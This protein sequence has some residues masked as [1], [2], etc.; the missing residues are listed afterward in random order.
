[1]ILQ[2]F[3]YEKREKTPK[4]LQEFFSSTEGKFDHPFI[5]ELVQ[6]LYR[7]REEFE[8]TFLINGQA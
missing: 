7:Q 2:A 5:Q 1:M 4:K 6:E 3:E 8:K